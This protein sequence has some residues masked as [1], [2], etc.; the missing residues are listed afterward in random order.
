MNSTTRWAGFGRRSGRRAEVNNSNGKPTRCSWVCFL[1]RAWNIAGLQPDGEARG[2]GRGV[3]AEKLFRQGCF[4][5]VDRSGLIGVRQH[6]SKLSIT[7]SHKSVQLS[8]R[9]LRTQVNNHTVL[10]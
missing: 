4:F 3:E 7:L 6:Q 10:I 5:P 1:G 8:A 9:I 2:A